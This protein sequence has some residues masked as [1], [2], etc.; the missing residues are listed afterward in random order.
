MISPPILFL[1]SSC[2]LLY[3]EV[4]CVSTHSVTGNI[5]HLE[6]SFRQIFFY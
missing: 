6:S 3:V 5:L 1:F 2:E 4:E